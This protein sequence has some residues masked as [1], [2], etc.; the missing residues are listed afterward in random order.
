MSVNRIGIETDLDKCIEVLAQAKADI[1]AS[2][3][4]AETVSYFNTEYIKLIPVDRLKVLQLAKAKSR[5]YQLCYNKRPLGLYN[6]A[7]RIIKEVGTCLFVFS[8][9]IFMIIFTFG[10]FGCS[11]LSGNPSDTLHYPLVRSDDI[12]NDGKVN[13]IDYAVS[14]KLIWDQNNYG[15]E[16]YCEI[17]RNKNPNNKM[18][19]LFV[20]VRNPYTMQW[21]YIEPQN[22]LPMELAWP[23]MYNPAFNIFGETEYWLRK[24]K[25]YDK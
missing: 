1:D 21:E 13:C 2:M 22:G 15:H 10:I 19:H 25:Q 20:R 23:M 8:F 4:T 18:H 16:S 17:V 12:N 14:Y 7:R 6:N 11:S 9:I 5:V 3:A 24:G